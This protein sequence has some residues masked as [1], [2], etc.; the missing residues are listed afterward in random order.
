[1]DLVDG[2][3]AISLHVL[4]IVDQWICSA[5]DPWWITEILN[6]IHGGPKKWASTPSKARLNFCSS[7]NPS[8]PILYLFILKPNLWLFSP[9]KN[10]S[11]IVSHYLNYFARGHKIWNDLNY[12][13]FKFSNFLKII[14]KWILFICICIKFFDTCPLFL[15]IIV[16]FDL[17]IYQ[18]KVH[19]LT[20]YMFVWKLFKTFC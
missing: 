3:W 9:K 2:S 19:W 16:Y 5:L 11:M 20:M 17:F 13:D 4:S 12:F 18:A 7:L 6:L 1:M 10:Q 8:P 15:F 14:P